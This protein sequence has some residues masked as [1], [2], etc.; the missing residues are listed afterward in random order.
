MHFDRAQG[1]DFRTFLSE[2]RAF[3]SS[4]EPK[5]WDATRNAIA[6]FA[7]SGMRSFPRFERAKWSKSSF[8]IWRKHSVLAEITSLE[9]EWSHFEIS[10]K[11][12][13]LHGRNIKVE[14]NHEFSPKT[15]SVENC[16]PEIG[17]KDTFENSRFQIT[18]LQFSHAIHREEQSF[19]LLA[20]SNT[21]SK[22][23]IFHP[24]LWVSPVFWFRGRKKRG[25][26]ERFNAASDRDCLNFNPSESKVSQ[27]LAVHSRKHGEIC[28]QVFFSNCQ[29]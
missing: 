12:V 28:S 29:R 23:A 14:P 17:K 2:N 1:F 19:A 6:I 4:I 15:E 27:E 18:K 20:I 24:K 25:G 16:I 21:M 26:R 11:R 3:E 22:R 8:L 10:F 9:I 7:N 13:L 5:V